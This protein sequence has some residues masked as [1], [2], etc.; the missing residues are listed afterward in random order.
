MDK[1]VVLRKILQMDSL[2]K[3]DNNNI[4][5]MILDKVMW[6]KGIPEL[7]WKY[8]GIGMEWI[9]MNSQI[10][11][12][13]DDITETLMDFLISIEIGSLLRIK[14]AKEMIHD[15]N[16]QVTLFA[17]NIETIC[18][19]NQS[20]YGKTVLYHD[21]ESKSKQ[22]IKEKSKLSLKNEFICKLYNEVLRGDY[23]ERNILEIID[24][25]QN[26]NLID[27]LMMD[28]NIFWIISRYTGPKTMTLKWERFKMINDSEIEMYQLVDTM[29]KLRTAATET[30]TCNLINIYQYIKSFQYTISLQTSLIEWL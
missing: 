27:A 25:Y 5:Q 23:K 8:K 7:I 15:S 4:Y 14:L 24:W 9:L 19:Q 18:I 29:L 21:N 28:E 30:N 10:D 6:Q 11:E 26:Q 22:K 20:F 16:K 13:I 12:I 17:K 2:Y 1:L 3:Q